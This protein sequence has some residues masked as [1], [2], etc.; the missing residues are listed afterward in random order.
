MARFTKA[1]HLPFMWCPNNQVFSGAEPGAAFIACRWHE[2]FDEFTP[3]TFHPKLFSLSS[4]VGE[5]TAIGELHENHDAWM[6]HLKHV[7]SELGERLQSG[8]ERSICTP[9]H[10]G[11]LERLHEAASAS[12]VVRIGRVLQLEGFDTRL[13]AGVTETFRDLD[14]SSAGTKKNDTDELL[15]ALATHAFRKGC[16]SGDT[17]NVPEI[18]PQG[19]EAVR[20]W[21]LAALPDHKKEF[22]CIIAIDAPEHETRIAVLAVCDNVNVKRASP[23]LPGLPEL[24]NVIF[25]RRTI[26]G[27]R[28]MDAIEAVKAAVRSSLNLLALYKQRAAPS[29]RSEAWVFENGRANPID[30][31]AP[32]FRNLHPRRNAVPL[33]DKAVA[34]L[35]ETI[36]EPA[37]RSAL[38]LHNLALSTTDHRLRLVNLWSALECLASL[39]DGDSII[40]RVERLVCPILTWRKTDKVLRY[41]SISIHFWL[42]SNPQIDRSTLP[43]GLGHGGSVAAERVLTLLTEPMNSPG[44]RSLLNVVSGHPLLLHRVNLGWEALHEPRRLRRDLAASEKRLGWHL[45]RIYRARN[46]L[47]H[48]GVESE[49]LPQLANHL[50]QYLSWTL[51]RLLHGLTFGSAWT[52]RDSL[53]FWKSKADHLMISLDTQPQLLMLEDMFPE[54]QRQ[55]ALPVFASAPPIGAPSSAT[56]TSS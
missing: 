43:F 42:K 24:E 23:N 4:L 29:I 36:D 49:C 40:S 13:E 41:L 22:D 2:L 3:D 39:I 46:L 10:R 12:E 6:K 9:R 8:L 18:L 33:A 51:S 27:L 11:M 56:P 52:A 38:D 47:V 48:Q 5:A 34:A 15:T 20:S 19:R 30:D 55:P 1:C 53:Q 26:S 21:I 17:R 37:I 28:S 14:M 35:A 7:Q 44:I 25:L 32:S 45:W 16:S 50:Q 54:E 31:R